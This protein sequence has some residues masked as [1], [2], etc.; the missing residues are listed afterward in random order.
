MRPP[1]P[2]FNRPRRSGRP[3]G[4]PMRP[5][6][7][8]VFAGFR[9][10]A[11]SLVFVRTARPIE[12]ADDSTGCRAA[13]API[14]YHAPVRYPGLANACHRRRLGVAARCGRRRCP[15][16]TTSVESPRACDRSMRD[17]ASK[18]SLAPSE[19]GNPCDKSL[20]PSGAARGR[21]GF[22]PGH[23]LAHRVSTSR[24][25]PRRDR[26]G[27]AVRVLVDPR[28]GSDRT[29]RAAPSAPFFAA[30]AYS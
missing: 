3:R 10:V 26:H 11:S 23:F 24:P 19:R 14:L 20:I 9:P 22:A 27:N 13:T 1:A 21:S 17:T 2:E 7:R 4:S 28:T 30:G 12:D 25:S 6:M 29:R 16:L 5:A 18:A 15:P 8:Q